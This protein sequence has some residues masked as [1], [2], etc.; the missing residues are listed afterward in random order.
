MVCEAVQERLVSGG[1]LEPGFLSPR[2]ENGVAY[3]QDRVRQVHN[4]H[5][6]PEERY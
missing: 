5:S 3:F 1:Y 4:L 6:A 2:H